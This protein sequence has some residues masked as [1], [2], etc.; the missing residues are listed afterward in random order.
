M[1][2]L[3]RSEIHELFPPNNKESNFERKY[4]IHCSRVFSNSF[5][6]SILKAAHTIP[7]VTDNKSGEARFN[8]FVFPGIGTLELI[9]DMDQGYKIEKVDV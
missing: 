4:T 3:I 1:I 8:N 9:V 7:V 5:T 6:M 2:D